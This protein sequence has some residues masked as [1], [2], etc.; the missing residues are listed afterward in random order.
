V[1][2]VPSAILVVAALALGF[3]GRVLPFGKNKI[4]YERFDWQVYRAPHFDVYYYPE[5]AALLDQVVSYSESQYMRLSQILDH[6]I[7]FRIPL[8]YYKTHVEFEQTNVL[9]E[10][11]PEFVGAFADPIEHRMVLPVDLPPDKLYALIGHELTHV[12]EF[13]I[14]Y[15]E[16]LGRAFRSNVPGWI[17]EGLASHLGEDEDN[18]D[19]MIIRDAVV[20]GFIPPIHKV[21][22]LNF[23]TYRYGQAAFDFIEERYGSEGIRSFLWEFRKSLLNNNVQKPI[24]D[25]FG[26]EADEFDRQFKKFLQKRYLPVLLD[27]KEAEDYGKEIAARDKERSDEEHFVTFSPALSPSGELIAVMTTRWED[28]DVAI[29]SAKDGKVF[30]NLTKGFTNKYEYPVYGAFSGKKDL[31]WSPEGDKVAFFARKENERVLLVYNALRGDLSRMIRI[32]DVD[33]EL[34][35]AWSPDGSRIAF[36]GNQGGKVDIFTYD[37]GT[38]EV[39]NLTQDEFYDGNPSWSA[40]GTQI[41][42]N[43][44]INAYEKIFLVDVAD[45]T[46]K[47]QLTFGDSG[48]LQPSFSRDAKTVYYTSDAKDGIFNLHSLNLETGEIRRHTDV[49]G[50]VFTPLELPEEGGKASVAFTSYGQGRFRLFRMSPGEPEGIL[51]PADQT[52]EPAELVPFQPPLQLTLDEQKKKKYDKLNFHVESAP[53]VLVG[54]AD[55]GTV[56]SNAQILLS[57][58]LGDHRMFFDFQSVSTFSNFNF[59]YFNLKHRFN[60]DLFATDFR[61][62]FLVQSATT[63]QTRRVRQ[64]S[65]FTGAGA[66]ISYPFNRFYRVGASAGYFQ[67]SLDRPVC[68]LFSCTFENL[69]ENFPLFSWSLDGD[70]TRFKEFGPYHGQRFQVSQ[71]YAPTVSSSG[72]TDRFSTGPFVTTTLDY[73][74]YRRFTSRSLF[75]LR[76]L[77]LISNGEGF[78]IYSMGGL[79]QLRG[80]EFREF[81]GSRVALVNLEYRFPLVDALAFP[82]GVI[83]DIRAFLFLDI[84]AAW[85]GDGQIKNCP[86]C[87]FANQNLGVY[88]PFDFWDSENN[89]L[90]DGRGSYG[91][92]WNFYL[93]P[94][95]LTW[96]FAK[97]LKNTVDL[98]GTGQRV[99]DPFREDGTVTSF[100]IAREF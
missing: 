66:E 68:T 74:L 14:L 44:R 17:M 36:E 72:D 75:A 61:D 90:G 69:D 27:K 30:R 4:A 95:Q 58:L 40:D 51:R 43:R 57:D 84:G 81:F 2:R 37:L 56:L 20:S 6:E 1:R 83:R 41:L 45:P 48:D 100:Y 70:T 76:L 67:R 5:E 89:K 77:G 18:F 88:T 29:I 38:G 80:Y 63:G 53:S 21:N 34:S 86:Q 87:T 85:F 50:G 98:S 13:S 10:F 7:K 71:R 15:Q 9:L 31:T 96:S 42:Y 62:F 33:D 11:I 25:A 54:V 28:L 52:R 39:R 22:V 60:W 92:G 73:R 23:L 24:K 59:A 55:D 65:R 91:F 64:F 3:P 99:D 93:G 97:Q 82:I 79:N 94:F 19:R 26:I 78:D 47:V 46:R 12:F 49:V 8:I 16:S 35:P 32:P